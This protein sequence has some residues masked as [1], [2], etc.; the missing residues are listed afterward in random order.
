VRWYLA[1]ECGVL[2]KAVPATSSVGEVE[3]RRGAHAWRMRVRGVSLQMET[4]QARASRSYGRV[5]SC[6]VLEVRST[7]VLETTFSRSVA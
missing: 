4:Q 1:P 6:V 3:I 7:G 2:V 5:E